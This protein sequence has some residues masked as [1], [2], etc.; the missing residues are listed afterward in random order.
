MNFDGLLPLLLLAACYVLEGLEFR[1]ALLV[2][3]SF[4][5]FVFSAFLIALDFLLLKS[6]SR[7]PLMDLGAPSFLLLSDY[8][9]SL[10]FSV[11]DDFAIVN[12]LVSLFF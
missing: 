10:A 1:A 11:L 12:T 8:L 5:T 9:L 7:S 3:C 6:E 4:F 2:V